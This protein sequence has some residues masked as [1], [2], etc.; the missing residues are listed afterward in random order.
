L[1]RLSFTAFGELGG[2][3]LQSAGGL[4]LLFTTKNLSQ[5]LILVKRQCYCSPYWM[6]AIDNLSSQKL[7]LSNNF[8]E[9]GVFRHRDRLAMCASD[10]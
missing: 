8:L 5:L 3:N 10:V 9:T 6:K 7:S 2:I 4:S 1:A